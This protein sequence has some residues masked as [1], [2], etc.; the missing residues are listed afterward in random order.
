MRVNL[1][2]T[3]REY[4]L[5]ADGTLMSTTDTKGRITFC[6]RVFTQVSG[7]EGQELLGK[8]HN[9]IRH[10]DMPPEGFADLWATIKAGL[11]WTGLVKN[12]RKDGDH[13]WVRA[14]ATPIRSQ[15][16][17]VGYLS[18]RTRPEAAEVQAVDALYR[19]VREGK[20]KGWTIRNG[21]VV[22]SG[23]LRALSLPKTMGLR[24]RIGVVLSMAALAPAVLALALGVAPG[25]L[26]AL[27]GAAL[28][29]AGAGSV[30]L[31][32]QIAVPV[33]RILQKALAV[34]SGEPG[35]ETHLDRIDQIGMLMRAVN[36]AGLNLRLLIGDVA[37]RVSGL[38][39]ASSEVA[40]GSEDLASR[41]EESAVSLEQTAA[42]MQQMSSTITH[43]AQT[44][45]Q[46]NEQA[47][48]AST[49][50]GRG[51]QVV[52]QVV[53]KMEEICAASRK[54]GDIVGVIDGIAFQTNLLA[55]NAAVEA[56]RA[57]EQ[58]RG[59]AVVAGEVRNLSKRSAEAAREIKQ[60]IDG[61]VGAVEAGTRQVHEAGRTMDEI[62]AQVQRVTALIAEITSG[63]QEQAGGIGQI[64]QAITQ[65]DEV[66]Q[67]NA[68]LVEQSAAA[69]ASMS[70]DARELAS[71][72][73]LFQGT[74]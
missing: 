55:L 45:R 32:A 1:P 6:N 59:F 44:A 64:N 9:I 3:Q 21:I 29:G 28:A 41:T 13:Y 17:I 39:A 33:E 56:A 36:Q 11:P 20:A 26:W 70:E 72:L 50:A 12:R 14:N 25:T 47:V 34:S 38:Q 60:L 48:S 51:G 5:P 61:S 18:V 68:A 65:L 19:A 66:T 62:V 46:A 2:V 69:A 71:T 63:T 57:G 42:S 53:Q 58:G 54:I 27:V 30:L 74:A 43:N 22:R 7:Y 73:G 31:S 35:T 15:G 52:G 10:P 49:M 37:E 23:W 24:T 40:R 8:P 16:R 4:S 67:Q